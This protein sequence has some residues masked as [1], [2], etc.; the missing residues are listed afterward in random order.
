MSFRWNDMTPMNEWISFSI[1]I[2]NEQKWYK[3]TRWKFLKCNVRAVK[4]ICMYFWKMIISLQVSIFCETHTR[5]ML[6][7][8]EIFIA[9]C[10]ANVFLCYKKF[11]L[12]NIK[13][14]NTHYEFGIL[15]KYWNDVFISWIQIKRI[16]L[17]YCEYLIS[18]KD[19]F[20]NLKV[21]IS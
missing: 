13:H 12:E 15:W 14:A 17:P 19:L 3:R 2:I 10:C 18:M 16:I 20:P 4:Y 21:I 5:K 9:S 6:P 7:K 8:K 11:G 1:F